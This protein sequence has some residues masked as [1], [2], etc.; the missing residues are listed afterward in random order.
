[1]THPTPTPST[2]SHR[3]RAPARHRLA[4]AAL[5]WLLAVHAACV[6]A[7]ARGGDTLQAE[8]EHARREFRAQRFSAAYGRLSRLADAG[9]APSA[10]L[11]RLMH[12]HGDQ[13]FGQTWSASPDQ[14]RRW[15]RLVIQDARD[16]RPSDDLR[17][18]E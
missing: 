16:R 11:A 9:H 14:Q 7:P 5:G 12:A 13:L 2:H 6:A 10:E 1:M 3:H 4:L 15:A 18:A 17:N 8:Y